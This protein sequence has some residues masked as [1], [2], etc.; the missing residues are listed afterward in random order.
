[1]AADDLHNQAV[2]QNKLKTAQYKKEQA[3]LYRSAVQLVSS[4]APKD[5]D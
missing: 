3:K 2:E 5:N 1:M 4:G